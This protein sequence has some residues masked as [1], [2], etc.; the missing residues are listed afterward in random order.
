MEEQILELI[1]NLVDGRNE[2]FTRTVQLTPHASRP[3]MLSRYMLNEVC[4]LELVNRLYQNNLR[5]NASSAVVTFTL[6]AN[7]SDPVI[8]SPT[9]AQISAALED[10]TN[11]TGNC[12]ICQDAISSG[13][14]RIR[15]CNHEFHR[16]C[17]TNW[18]GMSVRC[19]VCRHDI[20]ETGNQSG[21][22]IQTPSDEE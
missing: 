14:C 9:Q 10:I 6:P 7:F 15:H 3:Q 22:S 4:I 13:G 12:A 19:P 2:F 18:F 5:S 8:V 16:N 1:E 21:A 20:R 17:L 11:S